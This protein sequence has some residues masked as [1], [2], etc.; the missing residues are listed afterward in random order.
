VIQSIYPYII[1]FVLNFLEGS[2]ITLGA[3]LST[4]ATGLNYSI[5]LSVLIAAD[6]ISDIFYYSLGRF[7]N[8]IID[9]KYAKF[10]GVTERRLGMVRGYYDRHGKSTLFFAKMSDVLAMPAIILAGVIKMPMSTFL[11]VSII[12]SIVK[13]VALFSAGFLLSSSI[14]HHSIIEIMHLISGVCILIVTILMFRYFY[15]RIKTDGT[16]KIKK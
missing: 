15:V 3:G 6:I 7:S 8:R 14:S 11:A 12:T 2:V 5:A 9:S 10:V 13:G 4:A 1:L 16:K